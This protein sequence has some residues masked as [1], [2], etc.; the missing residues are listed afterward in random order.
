MT[1]RQKRKFHIYICEY[2][3]LCWVYVYIY[4]KNLYYYLQKMLI[5]K[6]RLHKETCKE[7]RYLDKTI[8]NQI[9]IC[10]LLKKYNFTSTLTYYHANGYVPLH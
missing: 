3:W 6:L 5:K 10:R 7:I 9:I 2:V 4:F 8:Y 1:Q